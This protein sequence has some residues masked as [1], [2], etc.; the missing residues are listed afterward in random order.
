MMAHCD[1]VIYNKKYVFGLSTSF[2][3]RAPKT[4]GI[5][6]ADSDKGVI[7]YR[8]PIRVEW[9]MQPSPIGKPIGVWQHT[10]RQTHGSALPRET[11]PALYLCCF[12]TCSY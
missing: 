2:Q 1:I 7:C 11:R 6:Q 10:G 12:E 9:Q 3:N 8:E 5:S 4:L